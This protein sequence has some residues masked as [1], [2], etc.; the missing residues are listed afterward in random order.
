MS[1][2]RLSVE[3]KLYCLM[4]AFAISLLG[5]GIWA[6]NTLQ[7]TKVHGPFYQ[8]I[9]QDKNLLADILPPPACFIESYL[10]ANQ[11][12][13]LCERKASKSEME[14]VVARLA[15]LKSEY[16]ASHD[17]WDKTLP[18]NP[19]KHALVV[20]VRESQGQTALPGQH[21]PGDEVGMVF[22]D[23]QQ[24]LVARPQEGPAP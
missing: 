17:F 14:P 10:Y 8:Q 4:A 1:I 24:D 13:D 19:I 15:L 16:K 23:R 22:Q 18:D 11:L 20:D 12:H 2:N 7:L 9:V 21:L 6:H 3:A 5:Y